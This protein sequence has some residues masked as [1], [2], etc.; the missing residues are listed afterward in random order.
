MAIM[1]T[2]YFN[3]FGLGY[4]SFLKHLKINE[5]LGKCDHFPQQSALY[6]RMPAT[7]GDYIILFENLAVM[8]TCLDNMRCQMK[9]TSL[10]WTINTNFL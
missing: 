10:K 6:S 5:Y 3:E 2:C 1:L 7:L 4:Y 9:G 8:I